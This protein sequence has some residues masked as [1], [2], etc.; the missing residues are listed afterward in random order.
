MV[1]ITIVGDRAPER[2]THRATE[3][4]LR[5]A[6]EVALRWT[7]TDAVRTAG[8]G[9]A[10]GV[11]IAPGS[12]YRDRH[13]ALDAIRAAR[14][15]GIPLLGTCAGFQHIVLEFARSVLGWDEADHAEYEGVHPERA[16]IRPLTCS[17][18]GTRGRVDLTPG[19]RVHRAHG[20]GRVVE[21][22]RCSYGVDAEGSAAFDAAG[23]RVTGR[24]ENGLPRVVELDGHPFFV[25]TLYVPQLSST[26]ERPHP[27]IAAFVR[28][29][30]G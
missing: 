12:P 21:E 24:D 30:G 3:E 19:S 1:R 27:L 20:A 13:G 18:V 29:C 2:A 6:G 9:A 16:L 23:L 25:G 22:Y 28:A 14:T 17:L 26:A 10:D 4:A 5:H 11:F 7:A 8:L 15:R